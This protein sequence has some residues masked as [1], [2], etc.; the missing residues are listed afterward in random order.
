MSNLPDE[1]KELKAIGIITLRN[2][3]PWIRKKSFIKW[4]DFD[5]KLGDEKRDFLFATTIAKL[6]RISQTK[7][8]QDI[9]SRSKI[10]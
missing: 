10:A 3:I 8:F 1:S 6:Y 9:S 7:F 5:H 2:R 4:K